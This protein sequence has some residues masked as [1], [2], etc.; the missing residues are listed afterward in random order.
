VNRAGFA[1]HAEVSHQENSSSS[2]SSNPV[3][4]DIRTGRSTTLKAQDGSITRDG[5]QIAAGYDK[6]GLPTISDDSL[7]GDIVLSAQNGN[8]SLNAATGTLRHQAKTRPTALALASAGSAARRLA[9]ARLSSMS[10]GKG[11]DGTTGLTH[12]NSHVNGTGDVTI[13]TND[14]CLR[15]AAV[16]G[17]SVTAAVRNLTVESLVD[18]ATAE[19]RQ[20]NLSGSIGSDGFS[21]SGS[22]Q[23]ATGDAAVVAEQSGIHA[24]SGGLELIVDKKTTLVGG[25][26]TSEAP[27]ELNH[28]ETGTLEVTDVD[29][30][31]RWKADTYGASIGSGGLSL[32]KVNDGES[33]T[34][35]AYSAIGGNI[36]IAITD[37][38]HQAQDIGTIRRDTDNTNTSLPGLPDPQNVLRDQ[39][40]TQADLQEAQKTMAGL[41]GDIASELYKQSTTQAERDFWAEGGQGRALLH[42]IGGGI[43]GGV[44]GWGRSPTRKGV[45]A[46]AG[47]VRS[48]VR[49]MAPRWSR[50]LMALQLLAKSVP[51][52]R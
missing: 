44:N 30:H 1:G 48:V 50:R 46:L 7:A 24:G 15:G 45:L 22:T 6:F 29:T 34:G 33:E 12:Y 32:A 51:T 19:A 21:A 11:N 31:S 3:V 8:I 35:K 43:L 5:A 47:I 13:L 4:T 38:Q 20:L 39:Y 49:S 2:S 37:P 42:A 27:A 9:A 16:T 25:L 28:L 18:T 40:K 23:K 14:L 17:N 26:L 36:G 10:Y 41:V 52:R